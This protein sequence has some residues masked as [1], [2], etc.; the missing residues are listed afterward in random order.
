[1]IFLMNFHDFKSNYSAINA[2]ILHVSN[3]KITNFQEK[4]MKYF[5]ILKRII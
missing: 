2:I 1:M 4:L 5:M 3:L